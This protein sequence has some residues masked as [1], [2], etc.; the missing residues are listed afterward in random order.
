MFD[1]KNREYFSDRR[2][3]S[4]SETLQIEKKFVLLQT[5]FKQSDNYK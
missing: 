3:F 4:L 5:K 1:R 2:D